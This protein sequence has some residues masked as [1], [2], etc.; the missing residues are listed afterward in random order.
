MG[1]GTKEPLPTEL[2]VPKKKELRALLGAPDAEEEATPA[3]EGKGARSERASAASEGAA[4]AAAAASTAE[5][6]KRDVASETPCEDVA[7]D[8]GSERPWGRSR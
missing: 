5:R 2:P 7:A 6:P 3:S 8:R 4:A 1:S